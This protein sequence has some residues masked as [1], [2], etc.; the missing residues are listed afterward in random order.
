MFVVP[1]WLITAAVLLKLSSLPQPNKPSEHEYSMPLVPILP[2]LGIIGN[3][4]LISAF[5]LKTWVYYGFYLVAGILVYFGY[6]IT[7]SKL[8]GKEYEGCS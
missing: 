6:G 1:L 5:D 8:E 4:V 7:H 3:C 2:C